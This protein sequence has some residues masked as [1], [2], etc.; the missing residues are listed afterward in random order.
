MSDKT[1]KSNK[2]STKNSKKEKTKKLN[3]NRNS[4][5]L[6][7]PHEKEVPVRHTTKYENERK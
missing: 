2:K 3:N 6:L 5:A 7:I 1:F 4:K